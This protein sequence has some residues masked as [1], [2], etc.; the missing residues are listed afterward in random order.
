MFPGQPAYRLHLGEFVPPPRVKFTDS[1]LYAEH[2]LGGAALNK[3]RII[4]G[5]EA[6][7]GDYTLAPYYDRLD[8]RIRR[9]RNAEYAARRGKPLDTFI[10]E[11]PQV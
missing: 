7:E 9:F 5:M 2:E 3:L 8:Q 11:R 10:D 1:V 4:S 6:S